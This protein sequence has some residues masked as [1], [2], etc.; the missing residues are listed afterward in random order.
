[1]SECHDIMI[2]QYDKR[3]PVDILLKAMYSI[4]PQCRKESFCFTVQVGKSSLKS[5]WAGGNYAVCRELFLVVL[6]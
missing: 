1:M 2:Y 6:N 5:L 3:L 4:L